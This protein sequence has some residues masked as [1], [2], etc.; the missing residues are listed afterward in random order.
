M[1]HRAAGPAT[2]YVFQLGQAMLMLVPAALADDDASVSVEVYDDVAFHRGTGAPREVLQI[3][4]SFNS[5]RELLD[6]S[7]K[8]W[9]TLAIWAAEWC[10]LRADERRDMTLVTTQA[11]RDGTALQALT[12]RARD[13]DY[14]VQTLA[15]TAAD[16][17]GAA[18]TATDRATFARLDSTAQRA[19]LSRVTVV[20][21]APGSLEMR[22]SL[23]RSLKGTHE[24]RFI[25]ALADGVE[26]WWWSRVL[27]ALD[28]GRPIHASEMRAVIDEERRSLS[29]RALPVHALD[30]FESGDVPVVSFDVATFVACL[31]AVEASDALLERAVDDFLR[32]ST[33]RSYWMRRLLVG[34]AE[35]DRYDNGLLAEWDLR[36]DR[37]FEDLGESA[38]VADKINAGR[39]LYLELQLDVQ[40]P[41][42]QELTDQ[43]VQRGSLNALADDDRLAW[44]PDA[45]PPYREA[46]R[47]RSAA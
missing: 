21:A 7:V 10:N 6:T 5:G 25:P 12:Q 43:F 29:D 33:H 13:L 32:A 2:G 15:K 3:H 37:A 45:V 40:R 22:R 36:C 47:S 46:L 20:D 31:R 41:L 18:G 27:Y 17:H 23:E 26:G 9:R 11:A 44:H 4:H 34:P 38:T 8:T 16:P 42:R 28:D 39:A 35:L 24:S 19:L 1:T 30:A 14:A